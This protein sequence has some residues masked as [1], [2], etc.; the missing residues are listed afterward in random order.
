MPLQLYVTIRQTV[1]GRKSVSQRKS[2]GQQETEPCSCSRAAAPSWVLSPG[3]RF[4]Q[5]KAAHAMRAGGHCAL[6]SSSLVSR[7]HTQG[8]PSILSRQRVLLGLV[9]IYK[10]SCSGLGSHI[11]ELV[12]SFLRVSPKVSYIFMGKCLKIKPY[13]EACRSTGW[14]G[15]DSSVF[16]L[17]YLTVC[18]W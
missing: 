4:E 2:R 18:I 5:P 12:G 9:L 1:T 11:W 10:L 13:E 8:K 7:L 16:I 6:A 14:K 17:L 3:G 15:K